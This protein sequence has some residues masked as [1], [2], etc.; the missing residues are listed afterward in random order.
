V[1]PGTQILAGLPL[2]AACGIERL[3]ELNDLADLARVGPDEVLFREGERLEEL[4][5]LLT[6]F[7]A[8]TRSRQGGDAFTD[9]VGPVCPLGFAA[10]MLGTA[11]PN[12]ARTGARD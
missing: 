8:E 6:G 7:V 10:A 1:R 9:V 11:S 3:A 2:L 4:N 5:I 12:G